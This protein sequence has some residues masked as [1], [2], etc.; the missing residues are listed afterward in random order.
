MIDKSFNKSNR[1]INCNLV[2]QTIHL[3]LVAG[4]SLD[5]LHSLKIQQFCFSYNYFTIFVKKIVKF[6]HSLTLC[7]SIRRHRTDTKSNKTNNMKT[8]FLT[9]TFLLFS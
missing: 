9:L 1:I 3:E 8:K 5:V 4:N 2:F 6:F 7:V